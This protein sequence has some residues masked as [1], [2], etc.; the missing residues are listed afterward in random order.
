MR[1]PAGPA[2]SL[3]ATVLAAAAPRPAAA[4]CKGRISGD[5]RG[6]FACIVTLA[7]ADDGTPVF[8][9]TPKDV[10]PDI[11]VYKPG[12]FQVPA[13]VRPGTY[14]L[15]ELGMGMAS[16]AIDGGALYTATRTYSQ[17]GDVTLELRSVKPDRAR[18]GAYVVHGSYRARLIP[19]GGGKT[20]EVLFEVTF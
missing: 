2:I 7:P 1:F 5:A 10:L 13:P 19:A 18:P 8:T 15:A 16:L 20:G 6:A 12:S 4:A 11:P 9:I 14:R 17:R 3:A